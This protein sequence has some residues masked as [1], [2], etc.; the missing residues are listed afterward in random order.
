MRTVVSRRRRASANAVYVRVTLATHPLDWIVVPIVTALG[1]G[2]EG[3]LDEVPPVG[4]IERTEDGA[5]DETAAS[6]V[7]GDRV[8]ACDELVVELYVHSHV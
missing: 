5:T 6:T 2:T 3:R 8:N 4:L 7:A 1:D